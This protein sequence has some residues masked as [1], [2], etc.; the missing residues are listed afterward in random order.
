MKPEDRKEIITAQLLWDTFSKEVSLGMF[1]KD[2]CRRFLGVNQMFL[3]YYGLESEDSVIGKTDE[4]MGWH[5]NPGPFR[6]DE[7]R[8]LTE[9][10]RTVDVPGICIVR[11]EKR[12][13][14]ASKMPIY[15]DGN[16]VGL[17]GYFR[18]VTSLRQERERNKAV[19]SKDDITGLSN[20]KGI[21]ETGKD[22]EESY[23]RYS[24][25]FMYILLNIRSLRGFE[26]IYGHFK[27]NLLLQKIA[28]SLRKSVG[29]NGIIA[30][31]GGDEFVV[32][33]QFGSIAEI[34]MVRH[35]VK[36]ALGSIHDI[37]GTPCRVSFLM[38]SVIFSDYENF[39]IMTRAAEGHIL[40]EKRMAGS[41]NGGT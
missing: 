15:K 13:I 23:F 37:S 34:G 16:I 3:D 26:D 41:E 29:I 7:V 35:E 32:M 39:D 38:S 6:N 27:A 1:W 11:G 10:I 21:R 5:I 31:I 2:T 24:I 9:G 22:Y 12:N 20:T 30:H 25:D 14:A 8:V 36:E 19:I 4:D 18:D 17:L 28:D 33:K 40:E